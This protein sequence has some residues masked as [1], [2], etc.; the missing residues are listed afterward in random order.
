M[1]PVAASI[2]DTFGQAAVSGSLLL[3]VP[4]AVLAGLVSFASPCV[5]PLV[6][7][8][9]G[10][11]G[12]MSG[13]MSGGVSG[14]LS[15][16]TSGGPSGSGSAGTRTGTRAGTR[17]AAR[18]AAGRRLLL[19]VALFVAGFTAVFV[20]YGALAGS[21][22]SLLV[23]WQDPITRVLGVVVV[24]MGLAFLGFVPF[25]Q[26]DRRLHLAPRAGL[27]GA[28]LLGLTFGLGWAPC[29]GP[30]LAAILTLSLT[31]ASAGRGALLA[32]AFCAGLGLPFVLVALG[33][34]RSARALAFLRRHRLA[35][36][37]AGGGMLVVLGLALVTGVWSQ[38]AAW[39]QGL[40][41]GGTPF[42]PVV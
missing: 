18:T 12:G 10:Y 21:L 22:G 19:G 33:L 6:P 1:S 37:R 16:G 7:G 26:Q 28:P 5:L 38:W 4:V 34:E 9:L 39:L 31:D 17:T 30:T 14:G 2:G 23:R 32:V 41:T 27:W 3:A 29:I 15:G 11:L 40:L 24:L 42:V 8:Y 13:G 36:M 35:V 20:A 25:L